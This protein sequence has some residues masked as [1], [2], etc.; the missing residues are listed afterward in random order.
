MRNL[1][2]Y[3]F[4]LSIL[5]SK[6]K[7]AIIFVQNPFLESFVLLYFDIII[8]YYFFKKIIFGDP[9]KIQWAPNGYQKSTKWRPNGS[10]KAF[11]RFSFRISKNVKPCRDA[12]QIG[13]SFF[14]MFQ[15]FAFSS[16]SATVVEK[17]YV[18]LFLR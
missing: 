18:F 7:Q 3:H 12:E 13:P 4:R 2:F 17:T 11:Q 5:A 15:C 10:L 16:F 1:L 8:F 6:I 14:F 9:F